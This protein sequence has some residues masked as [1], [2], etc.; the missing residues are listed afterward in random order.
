VAVTL[1]LAAVIT[2]LD[3][4][5]GAGLASM[6]VDFRATPGCGGSFNAKIAESLIAGGTV[7]IPAVISAI[8]SM[9]GGL[10][11]VLNLE[12]RGGANTGGFVNAEVLSASEDSPSPA[13]AAPTLGSAVAGSLGAHTAFVKITYV[14]P[15]GESAPS[16]E[17]TR[18]VSANNE[19]TVASPAAQAG[20]ASYNVYATDGASGTETL[21]NVAPI[22][23]G[24][25][26]Q[27]PGTGITSTG[28]A[29]PAGTDEAL[30][31]GPCTVVVA[32]GSGALQVGACTVTIE[33]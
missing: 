15:T 7:S 25:G 4:P 9:G 16:A 31:I 3:A 18:A 13:P 20:A 12:F 21:Q 1:P 5:T 28:A 33:Q 6:D 8:D 10:T 32:V 22:A 19:L 11:G 27:E 26:W 14:G 24:T 2:A 30:A 29:V 23:I 17:S